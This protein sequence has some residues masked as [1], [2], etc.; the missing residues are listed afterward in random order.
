MPD[1]GGAP[2][3]PGAD[4]A[5]RGHAKPQEGLECISLV[6]GGPLDAVMGRVG[7]LAPDRLPK[8]YAGAV[9]AAL[10]WLPLAVLSTFHDSVGHMKYG[11]SF[12]AD[13]GVYARFLIAP[14]FLVGMARQVDKR[15]GRLIASFT[16]SEIVP[17]SSRPD[18]E[19]LVR[20]ADRRGASGLAAVLMLFV[21]LGMAA[22]STL[23]A[24]HAEPGSW[25]AP[26]RL[27]PGPLSPAGWWHLSLS[28]PIFLFLSLRWLWRLVVWTAFLAGVS[29]L[30]LDLVATHPDR[31]GGLGFLSL[32]P[33]MFIPL[34]FTLSLVMASQALLEVVFN[35]AAFETFRAAAAAWIALVVAMFVGPL[36]A[37]SWPLIRLR[38][39][40][41]VEYG[42]IVTRLA[43]DVERG[44]RSDQET[45]GEAA[46]AKVSTVINMGQGWTSIN[47]LGFVPVKSWALVPLV[48]VS[49]L[50][51]FAVAAVK[52]PVAELLERFLK[53]L[54]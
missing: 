39:K 7:L 52:V 44:V 27:V 18:F 10:L 35:N 36:T 31:L 32:F 33:F 12:F 19:G 42:E 37:F 2:H 28:L 49:A 41:L 23:H 14:L 22:V 45:D 8:H 29:R 20:R 50:P 15:L 24:A 6:K 25:L 30:R 47:S 53:A 26:G 38:E 34:A 40:R 5:S 54:T 43:R 17:A 11:G 51:M 48:L 21:A 3:G 4:A 46:L 9:F 13:F 16:E 1:D